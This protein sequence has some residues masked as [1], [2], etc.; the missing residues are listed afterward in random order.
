MSA[1]A[2]TYPVPHL[3]PFAI[4]AA[5]QEDQ[6]FIERSIKSARLNPTDLN[7]KNFL[8]A[9]DQNELIGMIQLRKHADG[10]RELGSLVVTEHARNRG[11]AAHMIDALLAGQSCTVHMITSA[12]FAAHYRRWGFVPVSPWFVPRAILA[13]YLLGR[14]ARVISFL[15]GLPPRQLV[16][17][18]STMSARIGAAAFRRPY[19]A[20]AHA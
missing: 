11:V 2:K 8:V 6:V 10:S 18:E 5:E 14:A 19:K 1:V 4:R 12:P 13:N 17:L 3:A 9:T 7:W 15:R 20:G 16:I